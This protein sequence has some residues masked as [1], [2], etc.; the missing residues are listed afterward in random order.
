MSIGITANESKS[1]F[2]LS[3]DGTIHVWGRPSLDRARQ[4]LRLDEITVD[5]E[6]E[7][8][9]GALALA[10]RAAVPA[11]ERMV[12]DNSVIDLR[13]MTADIRRNIEAAISDS[14]N[15]VPGVQVDAS[16]VDIRLADIGFDAKTVRVIVEAEGTVS[17]AVT[18]LPNR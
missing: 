13:P 11:L 2:G 18:E 4:T 12:A 6:S 3:A 8:A 1:W 7:A 16:V 14:R 15:T 9:L 10:A 17:V 5:I